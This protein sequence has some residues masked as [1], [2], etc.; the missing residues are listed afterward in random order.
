[1][2]L[3]RSLIREFI[4]KAEWA[5]ASNI[6]YLLSGKCRRRDYAV[7]A[8]ELN[9]MCK[10]KRK[11]LRLKKLH[12][13][14]H[15]CYA[16][17]ESS[18][19]AISRQHAEHD[20]RLRNSLGKYFRT[21]GH[22]LIQYLT[23]RT[24]ADAKLTLNTQD[25]YFEFDSGHMGRKQLIEKI[26]AHY[27]GRGA[28]RVIFWMGTAEYAHWKDLERIKNLE[29]RRLNM[30][31]DIVTRGLKDKPNRVLGAGYHDYLEIGRLYTCKGSIA[32]QKNP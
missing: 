31:F 8:A 18:K 32:W 9:S 24:F 26:N 4:A 17:A 22:G 3:S 21:C 19:T 1:M 7:V 14:F 29:R 11:E 25:L 15:T 28:F 30:L 23:L 13:D 20:I 6:T 10:T 5:T 27:K 16:L 12:H 2:K